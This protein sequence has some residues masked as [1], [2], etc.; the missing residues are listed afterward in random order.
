MAGTSA[1]FAG[2]KWFVI[3]LSAMS[4]EWFRQGRRA[5]E[6]AGPTRGL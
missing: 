1:K 6:S 2:E 5:N 4:G 3:A